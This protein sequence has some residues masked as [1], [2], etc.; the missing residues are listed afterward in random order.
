MI[1][2][3]SQIT[4]L[5]ERWY[6]VADQNVPLTD[7]RLKKLYSD[8]EETARFFE[9]MNVTEQLAVKEKVAGLKEV[10]LKTIDTHGIGD[11]RRLAGWVAWRSPTKTEGPFPRFERLFEAIHGFSV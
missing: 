2:S 3:A 5:L 4:D 11:A 8:S 6:D 1:P 9:C 10:F 7:V